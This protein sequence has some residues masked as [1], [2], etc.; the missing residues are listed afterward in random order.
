MSNIV[1]FEAIKNRLSRYCTYE[2]LLLIAEEAS[3][4]NRNQLDGRLSVENNRL[5][6]WVLASI[7]R[8]IIMYGSDLNTERM[9]PRDL[10]DITQLYYSL[11]DP[12]L[13]EKE[14]FLSRKR[15]FFVRTAFEQFPYQGLNYRY[16]IPRTLMLFFNI[17]LK[18]NKDYMDLNAEF[19]KISGLDV[20]NYLILAFAF[21]SISMRGPIRLP[22]HVKGRPLSRFM[23]E[24]AVR[25]FLQYISTTVT[26]FREVQKN[27]PNEN[28]YEKFQFNVLRKFPIISTII[29]NLLVAPIPSLI[30]QKAVDGIYWDL[31][32]RF[33][34]KGE[35]NKFARYFGHVFQE[36]VGEQLM[37]IV[38]SANVFRETNYKKGKHKLAT[39]DWIVRDEKSLILVECKTSGLAQTATTTAQTEALQDD[40]KKRVV[41]GVAACHRTFL[42][43]ATLPLELDINDFESIHYLIITYR[44]VFTFNSPEMRQLIDA[45]IMEKLG[46][47]PKFHVASISE[48][49]VFAEPAWRMGMANIL[50]FRESH[51]DEYHHQFGL[52]INALWNKVTDDPVPG[53]NALLDHIFDRFFREAEAVGNTSEIVCS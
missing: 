14:E 4:I 20:P 51:G 17:H 36:Y 42:D 30:M 11:D 37:Q 33:N 21:F 50:E 1:P 24:G 18:D 52:S 47:L 34:V 19:K 31:F 23:T 7:A 6:P 44:E 48:I 39:C 5:H 13:D 25:T 53:G 35:E 41:K 49:E 45:E 46:K 28:G 2:G 32:D 26:A 22:I 9:I 38:G 27:I 12:F 40:M 16:E 29:P 10:E 15:S 3:K 43:F 8:W